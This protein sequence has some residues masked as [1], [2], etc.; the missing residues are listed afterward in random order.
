VLTLLRPEIDHNNP[1]LLAFWETHTLISADLLSWLG[2]THSLKTAAYTLRGPAARHAVYLKYNA[3]LSTNGFQQLAARALRLLRRHPAFR[4]IVDLR[5][6]PGGD[7]TPFEALVRGIRADP[8]LNRRGRILGLVN[9]LSASSATLD[10]DDLA[11]RTRA[12]LVGQPPAD[13]VDEYG[14]SGHQLR[15]PR[16]GL[17]IKY[18][19]KTFD[20]HQI[21]MGIPDIYVTPGIGQ[22]LAGQDPVLETALDYGRR[23]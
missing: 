18:T 15:L 22:I 10:A 12:V 5:D 8:A 3:C 20:P 11:T 13:P 14:N 9:Q 21:R 17:V 4:L 2:V 7:S 23:Q 19:T 6:N 1:G 16:S